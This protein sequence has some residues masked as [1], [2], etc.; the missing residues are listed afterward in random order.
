MI[1]M[2]RVSFEGGGTYKSVKCCIMNVEN[3]LEFKKRAQNT[4]DLLKT[5]AHLQKYA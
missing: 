4:K 3:V 1:G 2:R 5:N